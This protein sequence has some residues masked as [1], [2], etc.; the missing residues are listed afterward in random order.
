MSHPLEECKKVWETQVLVPSSLNSRDICFAS[1]YCPKL[2]FKAIS[3]WFLTYENE[4]PRI[5]KKTIRNDFLKKKKSLHALELPCGPI[6]LT[7][8]DIVA[9][10]SL[11][12]LSKTYAIGLIED[13]IERSE[14]DID[15]SGKSYRAFI[16]KNA[17]DTE[18]VYDEEHIAFLMYW[19]SLHLTCTHSLQI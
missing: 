13:Q 16:E 9:I 11:K 5:H 19:V 1:P 3:Y 7:L 10:I 12:P 17:K 18:E 8:L 15:F 14:I 2:D 4:Y 6:T